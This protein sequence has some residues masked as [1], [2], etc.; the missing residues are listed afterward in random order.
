MCVIKTLRQLVSGGA[1]KYMNVNELYVNNFD[2]MKR[3][4]DH[5]VHYSFAK[6][7]EKE[8]KEKGKH[9]LDEERKVLQT[10]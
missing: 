4:Y 5:Y 1:Y 3:A 6:V 8:K 10:A 7:I 2:L 9:F